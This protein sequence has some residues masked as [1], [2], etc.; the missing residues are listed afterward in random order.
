[1]NSTPLRNKLNYSLNVVSDW[2]NCK[3][4]FKPYLY[5]VFFRSIIVL[6][7]F[8]IIMDAAFLIEMTTRWRLCYTEFSGQHG[9]MN[10]ESVSS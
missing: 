2:N 7:Y 4:T 1:M 10:V 6:G 9:V 3:R 8:G 5:F